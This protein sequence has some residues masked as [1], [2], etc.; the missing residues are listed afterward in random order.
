M[1]PLTQRFL[2]RLFHFGFALLR[3]NR[4]HYASFTKPRQTE[5]TA[6][7]KSLFLKKHSIRFLSKPNNQNLSILCKTFVNCP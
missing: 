5:K 2:V 1:L 7:I 3:H 6:T 4:V